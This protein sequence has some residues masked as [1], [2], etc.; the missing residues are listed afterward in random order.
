MRHLTL[1]HVRY[2]LSEKVLAFMVSLVVVASMFFL[3]SVLNMDQGDLEEHTMYVLVDVL[4]FSKIWIMVFLLFVTI[5]AYNLHQYDVV[6]LN[7]VG[8]FSLEISRLLALAFLLWWMVSMYMMVWMVVCLVFLSKVDVYDAL[9]GMY[10]HLLFFSVYYLLMFYSLYQL[11]Q[12]L[13][14]LVGGFFLYMLAFIG[15]VNYLPKEEVGSGLEV[16][17][18]FLVDLVYFAGDSFDFYYSKTYYLGLILAMI[19]LVFYLRKNA[20]MLN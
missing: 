11:S 18:L 1:L 5:L 15:S 19:L 12:H 6:V 4:S 17:Y 9:V 7:R 20:D 10:G 8:K 16:L 14:G 13:L 2:L 3:Y